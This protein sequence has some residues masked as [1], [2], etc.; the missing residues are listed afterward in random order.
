MCRKQEADEVYSLGI[1][2]RAQPLDHLKARYED[3]QKRMM[4]NMSTPTVEPTPRATSTSQ[5]SQRQALATTST[6]PSSSSRTLGSGRSA[7]PSMP[8]SSSSRLQIFVDPTGEDSVAGSKSGW[9][10]LGTRKGRIKENVPETKKLEGSTIKQAGRAKRIASASSGIPASSSSKIVPYRD[11]NDTPPPPAKAA[12]RSG[13]SSSS[14][15]KA[16]APTKGFAIFV[17]AQEESSAAS[18][19]AAL[20]KF[21][22]FRDEVRISDSILWRSSRATN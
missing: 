6:L 7:L 21:T 3:F 8:S 10:E 13:G 12:S 20:P 5:Q 9:Q 11:T 4:T 2:R 14:S 17:D 15:S 18:S 1:A 19:P 22:P 16:K